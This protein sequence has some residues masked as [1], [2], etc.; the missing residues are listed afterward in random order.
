M[1]RLSLLIAP[2]ILLTS[3][4]L[5]ISSPH[6]DNFKANCADC[7]TTE[8]WSV[9]T[10]SILFD[11][12]TTRMALT[13]SHTEVTCRQCHTTL[14]FNEVEP[15]CYTCHTDV[16]E[17]TVGQHCDNCHTPESW[18]V[19]DIMQVHRQSRFPLLGAHAVADCY[20]CHPSASL[21]RFEP[22][23][24]A[25]SDCHL[26]DYQAAKNPDHVAAGYSLNCTD[27]HF[28][29]NFT[30]TGAGINHDFFPLREGHADVACQQCHTSGSFE[31]VP[32]DC[33]SC[34]L[35]D[36]TA[37]VNPD[38][39]ALGFG[40]DCNQCHSLAP[41]WNPANFGEHD[42]LFPIYSGEHKGE[43]EQ[44]SDCH[45]NP[46]N[47]AQ[48]TCTDCHEH[49][50]GDMDD[51]HDDVN[52]YEYNSLACFGC[53]P[54][55]NADKAFN[56]STTSFPLTGSHVGATCKDCHQSGYAGTSTDCF[57]CHENEF[58]SAQNPKH[59][60]DIPNTCADCHS[61]DPG[62]APASFPIHNQFYVLAGAHN[63]IAAKCADCHQGNYT[64]TPNEC[65]GCHLEEYNQSTNPP[66][67]AVQFPTNCTECHN[68][69]A[70]QPST[71]D[72]D[73][74]YFPIYSGKHNGEWNNCSDCHTNAT[75]YAVFSCIDCH[76]HNKPDMDEEHG[77][78][79]GYE[80]STAACFGCHP[81]GDADAAF[82]HNTT[83]FPLTGAHNTATC[84]DCHQNG[85]TGTPVNCFDCHEPD[86]AGAVNP[87]HG[88]LGIPTTCAD[89][90]TT[91]EGWAPATFAIHNQYYVLA[92]AHVSIANNCNDCHQGSYTNT[93]NECSGCH[94]D[95]YNQTTN[96]PHSAAQFPTNCTECH[97]QSAWEPST[98][99]HDNQYFPIYSGKHNGEWNNCSDCHTNP[100][101]YAVFS[102]IDCHE[103]NKADMDQE[104][105]DVGGY[106]YLSDACLD[107]HPNGDSKATKAIQK[108]KIYQER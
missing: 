73:N 80:Y 46:S 37:T 9:N 30:W 54:G 85:Y 21:L 11:H 101:N 48:F 90:H 18:I 86:F 38:H 94:L 89:C 7:H 55:G 1:R 83:A 88:V 41:G 29:G 58:T 59:A 95:D 99:N 98:F 50:K 24:I 8:G 45:T 2:L 22:L 66:H 97:N 96:P 76:E 51:E 27:C 107:C 63:E 4:K 56:H 68:E 52:G 93:P 60:P 74:Q 12:D 19:P 71:F 35:P 15:Y 36:Y 39:E 47:Y 6:G 34:H 82:N 84:S 102:C 26:E 100:N 108:I 77:G 13:G 65:S 33:K 61:T 105:D 103:H 87:N 49:N 5:L 16:H 53:H 40:V 69:T 20:D 23:G 92:G 10:D 62:W 104:H 17:N 44:C 14:V 31:P 28:M 78:V 106:V 81:T 42:G 32:A 25:C 43:W 70:W 91:N 72:H 67:S 79:N 64:G 57:S 75:N 3:M